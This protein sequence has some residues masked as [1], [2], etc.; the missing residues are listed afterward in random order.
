VLE[1][2]FSYE[3]GYIGANARLIGLIG[4]LPSSLPTTMAA[5]VICA[6][7]EHGLTVPGDISVCG[8]DDTP[9]ARQ[10]YPALT[11]VCQPPVRWAGA[12]PWS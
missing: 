10:I 4:R 8:F 2:E 3:S 9:I 11:T 5:G 12:R 6:V 7:F 1:G